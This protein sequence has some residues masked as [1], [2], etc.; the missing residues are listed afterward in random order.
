[1]A[2]VSPPPACASAIPVSDAGREVTRA[3]S[4]LRDP[5]QLP[6]AG[7]RLSLCGESVAVLVELAEQQACD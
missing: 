3:L 7:E 1:V 5:R 2:R 6:S 4:V